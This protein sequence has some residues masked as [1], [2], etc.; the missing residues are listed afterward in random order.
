MKIQCFLTSSV[1]A[2]GQSRGL[3]YNIFESTEQKENVI[4][5]NDQESFQGD[6]WNLDKRWDFKK[7]RY[8]ERGNPGI[9]LSQ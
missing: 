3:A 9:S 5:W 2:E 6:E 1:N 4:S 8:K 7:G